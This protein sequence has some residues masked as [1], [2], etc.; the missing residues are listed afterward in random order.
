MTRYFFNLVDGK[1]SAI[2]K[3]GKEFDSLSEVHLHALRMFAKLIEFIPDQISPAYRID[4]GSGAR[5][6]CR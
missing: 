6:D 1:H 2:D 3:H 4:V 5:L